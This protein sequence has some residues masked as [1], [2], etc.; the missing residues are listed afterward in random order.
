MGWV[1]RYQPAQDF[2]LYVW[3]IGWP[4]GRDDR[5]VDGDRSAVAER[6]AAEF[7]AVP[8]RIVIRA[9]TICVEQLPTG[10]PL[11]IEQA[12]RALLRAVEGRR[13]DGR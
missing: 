12:A 10:D 6:L 13:A 2:G 5:L 9:V 8:A 7:P 4:L 3:S 11:I 1:D